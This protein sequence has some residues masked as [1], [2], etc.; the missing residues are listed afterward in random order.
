MQLDVLAVLIIV[1]TFNVEQMLT[2]FWIP[3]GKY[4]ET[5]LIFQL[6]EFVDNNPVSDY[7]SFSVNH[8]MLFVEQ[9]KI[10]I[11]AFV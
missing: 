2:T 10:F 6:N 1:P 7:Q 8:R 4:W 11:C 5:V 9:I 3:T